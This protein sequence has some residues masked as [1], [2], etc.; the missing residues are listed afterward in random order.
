MRRVTPEDATT[1]GTWFSSHGDHVTE[2]PPTGFIV[3]GVAA[4]FLTKTDSKF[5]MLEAY[6]T[7]PLASPQDRSLALDALTAR[8]IDEARDCGFTT[9]IGITID[10]GL[11]ARAV[12]RHGFTYVGQKHG[13]FKEL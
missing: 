9:I 4:C 6:V 12:E 1:I 5:A 11:C 13:L 3:D 8:L 7:N 10:K 2:F